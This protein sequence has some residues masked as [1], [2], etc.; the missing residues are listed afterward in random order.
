M[1]RRRSPATRCCCRTDFGFRRSRRGKT[2]PTRRTNIRELYRE[3]TDP[4]GGDKVNLQ[5]IVFETNEGG[6][7]PIE[8]YL[9]A[10]LE[11][12]GHLQSN[13]VASLRRPAGNER[14]ERQSE[15]QLRKLAA[16]RGLSPKYLA[17]LWSTL[18]SAEPSLLLDPVR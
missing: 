8:R 11:L 12:R 7:L 14:G 1:R 6:R 9:A 16:E 2:G 13:T 3:F 4:R 17:L 10:T 5:G 15:E 18:T